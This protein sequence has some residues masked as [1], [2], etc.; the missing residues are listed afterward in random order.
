MRGRIRSV[1][2][3]VHTDEEL[4][5]LEDETGLP[6]FRAFVGLWNYCDR[7][8]RFEWR[9]RA[10]KAVILPYWDGDM[11]AVLDALAQ[12]SFIIRYEID[13]R[14]YG[15]VRTFAD[16]QSP[17]HKEPP[18]RIPAPAHGFPSAKSRVCD[19]SRESP[20]KPGTGE[21]TGDGPTSD[22]SDEGPVP[23][24]EGPVLLGRERN[25]TEPSNGCRERTGRTVRLGGASGAHAQEVREG[26]AEAYEQA[27]AGTPPALSGQP[28]IAAVEF[29]LNVAR[30]H[31]KPLREAARA[32]AAT[33]LASERVDDRVWGLSRFDPFVPSAGRTRGSASKQP[34][35]VDYGSEADRI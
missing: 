24:G 26:W 6:L 12:G 9:T 7:E 11:G 31:Q 19:A 14:V 21:S 22:A 33:T 2:P 3:E 18:S 13:G 27:K 28:F 29:A 8:G 10:L 16:H 30:T 20:G 15:Q 35:P 4:W 17:N 23:P 25:G 5:D 34:Q 1:K 32:I